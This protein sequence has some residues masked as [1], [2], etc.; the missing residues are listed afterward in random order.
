V[1]RSPPPQKFERAE[2]QSEWEVAIAGDLTDKHHDLLE[3]LV[4]L[5]PRSRGTIWFDSCG[6]SAYVGISLAGLIRL[7]GLRARGVVLGE[8][9]SA[10][11]LPFAACPERFVTPQSYL[12]FHPVRWSSEENVRIEEASEWTRHFGVLE[13]EMDRLLARLLDFPLETILAWTRPG[14]FLS[15][16]DLASAGLAKMVD[17]FSGDLRSQI[18]RNCV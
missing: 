18:A 4:E 3:R 7:R 1:K 14:R 12:Y 6:G 11:L 8:C 15:G 13:D 9:S 16:S 5:P 17:L 2:K 10:A